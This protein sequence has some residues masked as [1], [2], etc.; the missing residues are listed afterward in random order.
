MRLTQL[1]LTEFRSYHRLELDVPPEGL[2]LIG[3]NASGKSTLLEAVRMLSMLRSP[4]STH[5][6]D[7]INWLSGQELEVAPYAR[8]VGH[9]RADDGDIQ[10]ELGLQRAEDGVGPLRKQIKINQQPRRMQDSIGTVK[11]VLFTPEDLDLVNGSPTGR[12]RFIDLLMSQIERTYVHHLARYLRVLE[13]RNSLL[14]AH[15]KSGG[16][17]SNVLEQLGFW[18]DQ[19]VEHGS[20]IAAARRD[21]LATLC[22]AFAT[23][24]TLFT[25]TASITAAY[26]PNLGADFLAAAWPGD[27]REQMVA[28]ARREFE[29]QIK[30]RRD[31][32]LRRGVT[33][34]GP[35]RDDLELQLDLRPLADFGS[36]GQ[37][38]LAV[39]ALK[40]AESDV[41]AAG[42]E[43]PILLLDDVLSELDEEHR[44]TLLDAIMQSGAQIIITTADASQV[45]NT[46]IA[47]LPRRSVKSGT[48]TAFN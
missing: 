2:I 14:R 47:D 30:M 16:P 22:T 34:V 48:I 38:R 29:S 10:V 21:V 20:E 36:R 9:A 8:I 42:G 28:V 37:Q 39:V 15:V 27:S 12:R 18:D 7:V 3:R 1:Q 24:T 25:E 19:L 17:R 5:D 31:E 33:V 45:A 13:Q 35:H 40:L 46:P 4:R 43:L 41:V 23:R 6:R 11:S 44:R 26:T 32:E